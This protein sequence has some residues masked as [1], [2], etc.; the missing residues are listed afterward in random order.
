[1]QISL[2]KKRFN[3]S[4]IQQ[5][6]IKCII[7]IRFER[8]EMCVGICFPHGR[9]STENFAS[10]THHV[11]SGTKALNLSHCIPLTNNPISRFTSRIKLCRGTSRKILHVQLQTSLVSLLLF[12]PIIYFIL[13]LPTWCNRASKCL[14]GSLWMQLW[15]RV[16]DFSSYVAT[17]LTGLFSCRLQNV[18][19]AK[20]HVNSSF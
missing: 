13:I 6:D 2:I 4:I 8:A 12:K 14:D 3:L 10:R 11:E 5:F 15:C 1:M 17:I 9:N 19:L 18:R 20:Y 16:G 7:K